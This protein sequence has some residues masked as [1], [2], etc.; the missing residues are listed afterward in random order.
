MK[1]SYLFLAEGFEEIEALS[2]VDVMRRAG[3]TVYTVSITTD[4]QVKGANG[5]MVVADKTIS[6]IDADDA[7]WLIIPGGMPGSTNLAS[8]GK[9]NDMLT[10]QWNKQGKI[11]AICAAPAVVLAPLGIVRGQ[12]V[13]CYPTF[14][15]D[16]VNAG[17][18][19]MDMRVVESGNLITA[20][21]PSSAL[22]F[23]FAIVANTLGPD[24]ASSVASGMLV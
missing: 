19:Y 24:V 14:K 16:L 12:E 4:K 20:N 13:T 3:M 7:E 11:A 21:G 22:L 8:C 18:Q 1:T 10:M 6:D 9:L 2:T 17:G 15:D 23:A 5:I